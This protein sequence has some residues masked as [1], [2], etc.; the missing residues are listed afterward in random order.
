QFGKILDVE[1]IFNERGSKGFGFVTFETSADADRAREKLNGTIVE[2]RKIEVNNAT[3]RVMTNKKVS[4]PYTNGKISAFF[5]SLLS[6]F[7]H[8]LIAAFI[9]FFSF[10]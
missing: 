4:N 6:S 1:I 8:L 7:V 10:S 9:S 5:P 3:A 2:G